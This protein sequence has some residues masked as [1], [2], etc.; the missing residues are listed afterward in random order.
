MSKLN[1]IDLIVS[2]VPAAADFFHNV[3]G[4]TLKEKG[5]RFAELT[6][7]NLIH[8]NYYKGLFF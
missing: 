3:F 5:P 1:S 7:N 4:M 8:V 2:D 6:S